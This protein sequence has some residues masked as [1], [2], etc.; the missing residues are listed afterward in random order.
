MKKIFLL[1]LLSVFL[2][3]AFSQ[4]TDGN[5]EIITKIKIT[6]EIDDSEIDPGTQFGFWIF[7]YKN[8]SSKPTEDGIIVTCTGWGFRM[9]LPKLKDNAGGTNHSLIRGISADL[10]DSSCESV[11]EECENRIAHGEYQ[12]TLT[13]KFAYSDPMA[14]NRAAYLILQMNWANDPKKPYNGK[15]EITISK[16]NDFGIK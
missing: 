5:A 15:A 2:L 1:T 6:K 3:S 4:I 11:I 14:N 9:C 12:G 13:K 10:V 16:I 8:V 7:F